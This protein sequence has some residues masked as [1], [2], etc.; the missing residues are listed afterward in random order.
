MTTALSP[1][2]KMIFEALTTDTKVIALVPKENISDSI[3]QGTKGT[4]IDIGNL[5]ADSDDTFSSIGSEIYAV[6]HIW[7]EIISDNQGNLRIQ[8]IGDAVVA[9]L[10]MKRRKLAEKSDLQIP[11]YTIITSKLEDARILRDLNYRHMPIRFK[12]HVRK[13]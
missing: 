4:Y 10:D 2:Q 8:T 1:V 9:T 6:I 5:E 12:I 3:D 11:G 7:D 13:I